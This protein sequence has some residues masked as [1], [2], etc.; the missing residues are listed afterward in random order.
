MGKQAI[1][2]YV[3]YYSLRMDTQALVLFYPQKPLII[4]RA[5]QYLKFRSI[6]SGINAF[7][8]IACYSE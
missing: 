3:T 2:V 7:V 6:T 4:K 5:M 8:A 1:G